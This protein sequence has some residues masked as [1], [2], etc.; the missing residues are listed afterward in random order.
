MEKDPLDGC[1]M[2]WSTV[3]FLLEPMTLTT[4]VIHLTFGPGVI[5]Q[6]VEE[7]A[8]MEHLPR[9]VKGYIDK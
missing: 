5:T 9:K 4:G 8:L 3:T 2:K 6:R 1:I 7:K